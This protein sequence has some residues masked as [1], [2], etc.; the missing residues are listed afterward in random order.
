[1]YLVYQQKGVFWNAAVTPLIRPTIAGI[2]LELEFFFQIQVLPNVSENVI[3]HS[4]M[5]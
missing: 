3:H 2:D 1:M 4:S 5:C